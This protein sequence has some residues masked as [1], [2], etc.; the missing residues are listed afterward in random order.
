MQGYQGG[1]E[2]KG[3]CL[4]CNKVVTSLHQ[5]VRMDAGQYVHDEC[6]DQQ[7]PPPL[8]VNSPG[9]VYI[10]SPGM[11]QLH[12]TPEQ[13]HELPAIPLCK[14][15]IVC[16]TLPLVYFVNSAFVVNIVG[17]DIIAVSLKVN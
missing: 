17:S 6:E 12:L 11:Q 7:S 9:I 10:D 4:V 1:A 5:R 8:C 13:V 2:F 3:M 14:H 16:I 15:R